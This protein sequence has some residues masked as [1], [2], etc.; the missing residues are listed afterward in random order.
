MTLKRKPSDIKILKENTLS[1]DELK[2]W[3]GELFYGPDAM[4][5]H[6]PC[7][8][9]DWWVAEVMENYKLASSNQDRKLILIK[10][11]HTKEVVDAGVDI[12]KRTG[13]F[14]W[15]PYMV[16]TV[17]LLHDVARFKQALLGSYSDSKT[18]F[19]HAEV[20]AN[21]IENMNFPEM[22]QM[23]ISK[24]LVVEAVRNHSAMTYTGDDLYA[25]ITR[26]ADKLA[27]LR[28]MDYLLADTRWPEGKV[29]E[30]VLESY[31]NGGMVKHKDMITKEDV[32]IAW[33]S[34]ERDF[35]FEAT[36]EEFIEG[37]IKKGILEELKLKGIVI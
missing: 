6:F 21:M 17:C 37:G 1:S 24:E 36:R 22:E 30:R 14:D 23:G 10:I 33:L 4:R 32:M 7:D 19:N 34:W 16:G 2:L 25:K 5:F 15:D 9:F 13:E 27:L 8:V 20:G 29:N 3:I 31:R 12:K 26:D 28:Y 11:L 35:N 18:N